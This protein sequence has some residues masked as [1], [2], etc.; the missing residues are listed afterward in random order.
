MS[1][2]LYQSY[3]AELRRIESALASNAAVTS[4]AT[5]LALHAFHI[6]SVPVPASIRHVT[7]DFPSGALDEAPQI[8][9]AGFA[10]RTIR[11]NEERV[12]FWHEGLRRLTKR[13]VFT[14]DHQ[15]FVFRPPELV[16]VALGIQAIEEN[17]TEFHQWLGQALVRLPLEGPTVSSWNA[18]WN[19]YA[20]S[21][22]GVQLSHSLPASLNDL[23]TPE[24]ALLLVL[25]TSGAP[26]SL[27]GF[28]EMNRTEIEA[29]L[30]HRVAFEEIEDRDVERLAVL[31]AALQLAIRA[32]L[33]RHLCARDG[34]R[35]GTRDALQILELICRRFDHF[36]RALQDRHANREAFKVT[37]E[38]DVQ[39][40]MHGILLLHFDVVIPEDVVPARAGNKSRLDFLLKPQRIVV[41]TKMTRRGL[42]QR[43]A[44]DELVADRD[45]YKSHPDC[46]VLVCLVYD[47]A[48]LFHNAAAFE[49]D[50][51]SDKDHPRLRA[52]VCPQ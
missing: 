12:A 4:P 30:L 39:D 10:V 43:V 44:H 19:S 23:E 27:S 20:A 52:F 22:L 24:L 42:D 13:Q 47:P 33:D 40:L 38:Y 32:Q 51:N 48:R 35:G 46:D 26:L 49:L 28:A 14:R 3:A 17:S 8:A 21:L 2:L 7:I 31:H 37:D 34:L 50:L 11:Q 1:D 6:A 18:L 45:R 36:V 16:G 41:E 25:I 29:E 9:T 15:T 5:A